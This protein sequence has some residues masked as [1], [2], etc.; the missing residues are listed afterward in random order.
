MS[1]SKDKGIRRKLP[2]QILAERAEKERLREESKKEVKEDVQIESFRFMQQDINKQFSAL[3][4]IAKTL[5]DAIA[6]R[7]IYVFSPIRSEAYIGQFDDIGELGIHDLDNPKQGGL[8]IVVNNKAGKL[9]EELKK[10]G[11]KEYAKDWSAEDKGLSV[12]LISPWEKGG[13]NLEQIKSSIQEL[14]NTL[15]Q[16][17][18]HTP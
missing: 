7:N 13:P 3:I 17:A 8:A 6:K 1:F 14:S 11:F 15:E 9:G 12:Y 10:A 4:A 2:T 18:K 16:K 5:P